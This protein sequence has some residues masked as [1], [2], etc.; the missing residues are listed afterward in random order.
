[1]RTRFDQFAKQMTGNALS[2]GGT[3]RTDEEVSPE[4]GHIDIWFTP[5]EVREGA[6][7]APGGGVF[8]QLGMLG[9]IARVPFTMEP[10][11]RTP[12]GLDVMGVVCKHH[13][14]RGVLARRPPPWSSPPWVVSSGRP[15]RRSW[16]CGSTAGLLG[17]G[18]RG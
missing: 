13:Y 16:G 10:F 4:V 7:E 1:M 17:R 18:D 8:A 9:R 12:D 11:H 6:E 3:V 2:A 15:V 14:F 5:F